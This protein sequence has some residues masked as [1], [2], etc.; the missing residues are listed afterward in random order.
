MAGKYARPY[1]P[2]ILEASPFPDEV[3]YQLEGYQWVDV[4]D[5][6]AQSWLPKLIDALARHNVVP[7]AQGPD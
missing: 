3:E 5:Q 4:L 7:A 1:I 6:P 2:L